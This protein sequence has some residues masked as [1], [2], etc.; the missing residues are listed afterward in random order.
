M[1]DIYSV[2][3][4]DLLPPNLK[5][6]PDM[7]AASKAVDS[8]FTLVVNEVQDC[9]ILP[10]ID[11]LE[12]D[13]VDLLAWELHVDFYD[14]EL[15]V[16]TRRALVKNSVQAHRLKGTPA[17]VEMV[18]ST[19]FGRCS[20][21]EWFNYGGNPYFFRVNVE[22][23]QQGASQSNLTKL[24]SLINEYKNTRSWLEIV[25]IFLTSNSK[26]YVAAA[27]TTGESITVYPWNQT[28][29]D[30]NSLMVIGL[31]CQSVETTTVYPL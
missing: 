30:S 17:A 13:L 26:F 31:G 24:E 4:L 1:I 16:E 19:V 23:S 28:E 8:E 7:I 21:D 6:D 27:M 22:A 29:V 10:R 9:I 12:S 3:V 20:L 15:P 18:A 5:Q 14:A 11:E 25:N 2:S